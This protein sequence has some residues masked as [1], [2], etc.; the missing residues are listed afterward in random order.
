MSVKDKVTLKEYFKDGDI[1]TEEDFIDLIDTLVPLNSSNNID[2]STMT[3]IA[4]AFIGDGSRLTNVTDISLIAAASGGWDSTE[5][6]VNAN[7][8]NWNSAWYI[9]SS[10]EL[11]TR[12]INITGDGKLI[13]NINGI[14]ITDSNDPQNDLQ[15]EI[16]IATDPYFTI[17]S[18]RASTITSQENWTYWNGVSIQPLPPIGL[19][20]AYQD[21][22][23]GL[24]TYC[25]YEAIYGKL[26][27][28]RYRS[29]YG[30]IWS[31]YIIRQIKG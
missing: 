26:Y 14:I 28:I 21:Q 5:T 1:P 23:Y 7:S 4:S 12:Y 22:Y 18:H 17:F 20:P 31:D 30:T 25:W 29:G 8:A 10:N 11:D 2:D 16:D 9:L 6:I 15:F 27:Y 19:M 3:I 24:V 13:T